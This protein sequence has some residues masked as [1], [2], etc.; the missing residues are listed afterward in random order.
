MNGD[1]RHGGARGGDGPSAETTIRNPAPPLA[2]QSVTK[3]TA[4]GS[5]QAE[6]AGLI[7]AHAGADSPHLPELRKS[8]RLV[9]GRRLLQNAQW[10]KSVIC[11]TKSQR[12]N[13][14]QTRMAEIGQIASAARLDPGLQNARVH[15]PAA[16]PR[17]G[18]GT[19][20]DR[21]L[22]QRLGTRIPRCAQDQ[23]DGRRAVR[24]GPLAR[25]AGS[26]AGGGGERGGED[27]APR[28]PAAG[29]DQEVGAMARTIAPIEQ[30]DHQV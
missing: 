15:A 7:S 1:S 5:A 3:S 16:G 2:R 11:C 20:S 29:P 30:L 25:D 4:A 14:I 9:A 8:L 23:S 21:A 27:S 26:G 10:P 13:K 19:R 6:F 18:C 17:R 12:I 24:G 22:L 28:L